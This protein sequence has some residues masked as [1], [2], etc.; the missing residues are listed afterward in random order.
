MLPSFSSQALANTAW[1]FA[2]LQFRHSALLEQIGHHLAAAALEASAQDLANALWAFAKMLCRTQAEEAILA[3]CQSRMEE[4]SAQHLSNTMWAF[5][6][7]SLGA[8][9]LMVKAGLQWR[10]VLTREPREWRPQALENTSWA[11]AVLK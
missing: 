8:E 6:V 2:R 4:F 1:A 9:E 11:L 5:A 7:L 10:R 3:G